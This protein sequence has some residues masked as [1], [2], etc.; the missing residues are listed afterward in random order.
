MSRYALAVAGLLCAAPVQAESLIGSVMELLLQAPESEIQQESVEISDEAWDYVAGNLLTTFYHELGHALIH[1]LDLP[2][3]GREEDAAD[4]LSVV[5]TEKI[6]Q[7]DAASTYAAAQAL[8]YLLSADSYE[9]DETALGGVHALDLQRYYTHICLFYGANPEAREEWLSAFDLPESRKESCPD[10]FAQAQ[11]GWQRFLDDLEAEAPGDAL[12]FTVDQEDGISLLIA[13]EVDD[14]NA[15]FAL[16]QKI[17]VSYESCEEIN[18]YYYPSASQIVI[19]TEYAD[20]LLEQ[21][22]SLDL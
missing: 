12:T 10:E 4:M 22:E 20:W 15:L 5:L 21:A 18:A 19:C 7:E 6:W 3:L 9:V 8:S 14:L 1:Q 16:P 17:A 2:V 13:Q 11:S